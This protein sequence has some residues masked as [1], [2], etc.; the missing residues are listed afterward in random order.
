MKNKILVTKREDIQLPIQQKKKKK[1]N[2]VYY[3][4]SFNL[5]FLP[6]N[7]IMKKKKKNWSHKTDWKLCIEI[8]IAA[9]PAAYNT[10]TYYCSVQQHRSPRDLRNRHTHSHHI[11]SWFFFFFFFLSLDGSANFFFS[12]FCGPVCLSTAKDDVYIGIPRAFTVF[13]SVALNLPPTHL[14]I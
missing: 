9:E 7:V 12:F 8:F 11:V 5:I 1:K 6:R 3:L 13:F 14:Y 2:G 10:K 4:P